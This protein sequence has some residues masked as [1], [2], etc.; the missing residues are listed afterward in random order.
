MN[1]A[2][3]CSL[4]C[5]YDNPFPP[6]FLAPIDCLKIPAQLFITKKP[7]EK[8]TDRLNGPTFDLT[9][10]G[11][12]EGEPAHPHKQARGK[13]HRQIEQT[14]FWVK[15]N[16]STKKETQLIIACKPEEKFTDR[17]NGPTSD[18]TYRGHEEGPS[19]SLKTSRRKSIISD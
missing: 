18:L 5:R 7:E 8:Y 15:P 12:E 6:R 16:D 2:I 13:V 11:H 4:A 14:H 1:S 10:R 9:Y 3:L 17:L 19:S